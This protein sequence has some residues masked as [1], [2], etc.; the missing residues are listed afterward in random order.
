MLCPFA[1]CS[2][3]RG[4]YKDRVSDAACTSLLSSREIRSSATLNESRHCHH[5]PPSDLSS[6]ISRLVGNLGPWDNAIV[7]RKT[8]S[9]LPIELLTMIFDN[10]V[11][12]GYFLCA[13]PGRAKSARPTRSWRESMAVKRNIVSVC[14]TWYCM[15]IFLLYRDVTIFDVRGLHALWWTFHDSPDLAKLVRGLCFMFAAGPAL[16]KE[17]YS[18]GAEDG[19]TFQVMTDIQVAC[20]HVTRVDYLLYPELLQ[21]LAQ[22]DYLPALPSALKSLGIG[23]HILLKDLGGTMLRQAWNQ[24]RELRVSFDG[25]VGNDFQAL[26]LSL[27]LLHTLQL[28]IDLRRAT[29]S[30]ARWT[31]PQLKRVTFRL[32][33][34]DTWTDSS[35]FEHG[36]LT[37]ELTRFLQRHGGNLEYLEFPSHLVTSEDSEFGPLITLCPVVQHVVLPYVATMFYTPIAPYDPTTGNLPMFSFD[38]FVPREPE[39]VCSFPSVISLD[40]WGFRNPWCEI[41]AHEK[42]EFGDRQRWPNVINR[43]RLSWPLKSV[44]LDPPSA[45]DP[46][47]QWDKMVLPEA[48][49]VRVKHKDYDEITVRLHC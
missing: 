18:E 38:S 20:P 39:P 33:D 10:A 28:T 1:N 12:P 22:W 31:M 7:R 25:H 8:I 24:L 15:G 17:S 11:P 6:Y 30:T 47:A 23:S 26:H 5:A 13:K 2:P 35:V 48:T 14:K 45:L 44:I 29:I 43:R 27:P 42:D 19:D 4:R 16:P 41:M 21:I 9:S 32:R 37:R 3:K 40:V 34:R 46:H 49:L 36:A